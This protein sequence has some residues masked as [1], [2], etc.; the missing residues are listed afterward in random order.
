[1]AACRTRVLPLRSGTDYLSCATLAKCFTLLTY[2]FPHWGEKNCFKCFSQNYLMAL[3]NQLK[4]A[5]EWLVCKCIIWFKYS[6][7]LHQRKLMLIPLWAAQQWLLQWAHVCGILNYCRLFFVHHQV[8]NAGRK[9]GRRCDMCSNYEKALQAIQGQEAET[10]DQVSVWAASAS[11]STI[12]SMLVC[13]P[14]WTPVF[15]VKKL[16]VML[17]QANEQ[18]ERT[19]TDKQKLEDSV[20]AA[21]KETAAKVSKLFLLC[22]HLQ[23]DH[24]SCRFLPSRVSFRVHSLPIRISELLKMLGCRSLSRF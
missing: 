5:K 14:E 7:K 20:Q 10:R 18:L 4:F 8:K 23:F 17:R 21:N 22:L 16:Q 12:S 11:R 19:M 13:V 24:I 3:Y 2:F 1:M 6:V 15:Q 9:L